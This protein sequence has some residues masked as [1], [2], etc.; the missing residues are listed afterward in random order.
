MILGGG[1]DALIHQKSHEQRSCVR[2]S[3]ARSVVNSDW[4]RTNEP[5]ELK[6]ENHEQK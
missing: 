3:K 1:A 4:P 6:G 2:T 5:N